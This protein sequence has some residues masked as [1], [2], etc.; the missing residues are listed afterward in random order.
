MFH[1]FVA[2]LRSCSATKA[3]DVFGEKFL[4]KTR[5]DR[6]V[7]G[8]LLPMGH[9]DGTTWLEIKLDPSPTLLQTLNQVLK[10]IFKISWDICQIK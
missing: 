9:R 10:H 5:L 3:A 6:K 7:R 2:Y 1:N 8:L 4:V